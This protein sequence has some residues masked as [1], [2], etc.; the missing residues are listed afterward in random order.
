MRL[1]GRTGGYYLFWTGLVY[2][3]VA[4]SAGIYK[5][6]DPVFAQMG[7]ITVMMLPLVF[8]PLGRFFNM[9]IGWDRRMFDFFKKREYSNVVKFP[10]PVSSPYA[11]PQ[12][13]A[14]EPEPTQAECHYTVGTD[15]EGK[16]VLRVGGG[17]IIPTILTMNEAGTRQLIRMLEAALPEYEEG[18]E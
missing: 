5:W 14:P 3:V 18:N 10:E 12:Y 8:P 16:V 11:A 13:T 4:T 7:W 9:S 15:S 17:N 6:F 1:F 2:L